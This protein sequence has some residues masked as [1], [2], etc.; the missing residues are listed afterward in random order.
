MWIG[1]QSVLKIL[2]SSLED[3]RAKLS[4][5]VF[6]VPCA[7]QDVKSKE[8]MYCSKNIYCIYVYAQLHYINYMYVL[9]TRFFKIYIQLM[10]HSLQG[11]SIISDIIITFILTLG[12]LLFLWS[13]YPVNFSKWMYRQEVLFVPCQIPMKKTDMKLVSYTY[14]YN[15]IMSSSKL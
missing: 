12:W 7:S 5:S 10:Y 8:Y 11:Y 4:L 1:V 2:N 15:S 3:W 9:I 6:C 14:M 13:T